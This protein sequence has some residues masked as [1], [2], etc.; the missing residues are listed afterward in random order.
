MIIER[1]AGARVSAYAVESSFGWLDLDENASERVSEL[2]RSLEE[3]TTLD[4]LGLGVI[5]DVFSTKLSPGTST[6]QTRLRYFIFLPW[7]FR[8]IEIERVAPGDFTDR[9][10][11]DEARLIDRL[12]H[13]GQ[14]QGVIGYSAGRSLKRMPSAVYW[15]GLGS[16]G[17]RRLD[18]SLTEYGKRAFAVGRIRDERDDDGD[19][20]K[21][22]VSMWSASPPLPED[23]LWEDLTFDL[24]REEAWFLADHI[25]RHHPDSLLA[26]LC[27]ISSR[28]CDVPYPWD[29]S[30]R[31]LSALPNSLTETLRHA[32]C[33]SEL[34]LGPQLVYNMLLARKARNELGWDTDA[35]EVDQ[36]DGLHEW[37]LLIRDR[38]E[39]LRSW[40]DDLPEFWRILA[41][42]RVGAA[43]RDFV[44]EMVRRAVDDPDGF[45]ED[46]RVHV[47]IRH[48]ELLLKGKRARLTQRTA[49]EKWNQ[50][51]MG[52][53]LDYRWP[54]TKSYLADLAAAGLEA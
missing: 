26:A 37:G 4:V 27:G 53:Q 15:G 46:R 44:G 54:I 2:L 23:F 19:V 24:E 31:V 47:L 16:W 21:R 12:R 36:R 9:L 42:C 14:N 11:R 41:G 50:K 29:L 5:R 48:R 38:H 22:P 1:E 17:V 7:I 32:R 52:L 51:P 39:A 35:L 10:H 8:R 20:T 13:L 33:F 40:V 30:T 3:P 25:R 45:P 6:I 43:T 28:E 49:L 18:L 34:T